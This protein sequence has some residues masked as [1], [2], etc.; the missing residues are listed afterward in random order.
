[1]AG[2][3]RLQ[4]ACGEPD[5]VGVYRD[6]DDGLAGAVVLPAGPATEHAGQVRVPKTCATWANV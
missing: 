1:M 2:T 3:V 5:D 6:L 4:A